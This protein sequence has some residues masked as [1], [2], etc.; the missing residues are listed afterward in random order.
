MRTS[1]ARRAATVV[2]TTALAGALAGGLTGCAAADL[3]G[4]ASGAT[5]GADG[6]TARASNETTSDPTEEDLLGEPLDQMAGAACVD[7][8]R[9]VD[10][11]E[12]ASAAGAVLLG[13]VVE[14]D[15]TADLY[16]VEAHRWL[17]DVE[18][19]LE[20]PD[21]EIPG[22]EPPEELAISPGERISVVSTPE[23]CGGRDSAYPAGD[24]LDPATAPGPVIVLLS[25]STEDGSS[26]SEVGFQLITPFQGVVPPE[27]DG[28]LP[29]EWPEN[30]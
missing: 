6:K 11:A 9:F 25:G 8:V 13:N 5:G 2:M 21:S 27:D 28:A 3:P 18:E 7:W 22:W 10:P 12:A 4:G 16:G 15:G 23:T 29:A 17:F 26:D 24:P 1:R 19:V 20:R 30:P 14:R